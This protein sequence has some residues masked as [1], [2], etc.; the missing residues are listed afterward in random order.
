MPSENFSISVAIGS[1]HKFS[2][3]LLKWPFNFVLLSTD[4]MQVYGLKGFKPVFLK[5][6]KLGNTGFFMYEI[7][8]SKFHTNMKLTI[9][10]FS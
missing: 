5:F 8:V 1:R 3:L 10:F 9:W 6:G 7:F 2:C 4:H